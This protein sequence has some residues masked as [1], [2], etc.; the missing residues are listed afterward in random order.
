MKRNQRIKIRTVQSVGKGFGPFDVDTTAQT[1]SR[2]GV[3]CS[4]GGTD[5]HVHPKGLTCKKS[6]CDARFPFVSTGGR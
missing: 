5:F 2:P 6:L 4:C 3:R 1:W